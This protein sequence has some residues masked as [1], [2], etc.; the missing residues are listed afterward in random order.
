MIHLSFCRTIVPLYYYFIALLE[1]F[2]VIC[3]QILQ[4]GPVSKMPLKAVLQ[5]KFCFSDDVFIMLFTVLRRT[6][7]TMCIDSTMFIDIFAIFHNNLQTCHKENI[8]HRWKLQYSKSLYVY[9]IIISS[10]IIEVEPMFFLMLLLVYNW[11]PS[12][13]C[14]SPVAARKQICSKFELQPSTNYQT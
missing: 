3:I 9:K 8:L 6:L 5:F 10:P 2:L 12:I 13:V 4:H 1:G 7:G 11:T 14:C